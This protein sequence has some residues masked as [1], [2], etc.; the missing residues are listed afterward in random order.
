MDLNSKNS[1][2]NHI[3]YESARPDILQHI[4]N[5]SNVLDIGCSNGSLGKAIKCKFPNSY[6]VGID[7]NEAYV[8]QAIPIINE[9]HILNLQNID[10]LKNFLLNKK[11]DTIIAADVLE[12][13]INPWE[14]VNIL[15]DALEPN[16]S[17]YISVPNLA[18][19]QI[20]IH[21]IRLSWPVR[22]RGIY[23]KTHFRF[24]MFNDLKKLCPEGSVFKL[25]DRNYRFYEIC[26]SSKDKCVKS[27]FA[28]IPK[29]RE[30]FVFQYIFSISKSL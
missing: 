26:K 13:T 18:H 11:F 4:N 27:I 2:K 24:F 5:A 9:A 29:I 15:Y 1:T 16:G 25:L 14:I 23:D 7:I 28:K 12:H 20:F 8:K 3:A 22:D 6:I 19:W 17:I 21:L 30:Y 10:S